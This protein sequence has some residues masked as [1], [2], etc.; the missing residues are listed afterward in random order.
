MEL[1]A[2]GADNRPV[3]APVFVAPSLDRTYSS[4]RH[5]QWRGVSTQGKEAAQ[6]SLF[7][8]SKCQSVMS[9]N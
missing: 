9:R 1:G 4:G 5:K 8:M 7:N 3:S 6:E 2:V